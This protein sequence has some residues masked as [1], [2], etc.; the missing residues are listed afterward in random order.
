[1]F[2]NITF[3]HRLI[4]VIFLIS[5]AVIVI[6]AL[7]DTPSVDTLASKESLPQAP[8]QATLQELDKIE[9]AF[10]ELTQDLPPQEE[11][12]VLEEPLDAAPVSQEVVLQETAIQEP[13]SVSLPATPVEAKVIVAQEK[14]A[15]VVSIPAS[16]E[17]SVIATT[18]KLISDNAW[19][20]QLGAFSKVANAQALLER[21]QK[22]GYT[23][24]IQ[25]M[26]NVNLTRVL[27]GTKPD[28]QQASELLAELDKTM[29]LKGIVVKFNPND[30]G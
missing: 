4:G 24:Y 16:G 18:E 1:M 9:Y 11:P 8:Q 3:K 30:A 12:A 28:K 15:E 14:P 7:F 27:V 26:S 29:Q 20:V 10:A 25:H 23:A 17:S 13:V 21:L 2:S 5:L 6:P 22:Q 19:A